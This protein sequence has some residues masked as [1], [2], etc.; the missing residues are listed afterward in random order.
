MGL[1]HAGPAH[2]PGLVFRYWSYYPYA[3][4]LVSLG[5]STGC[6]R[7]QS[8]PKIELPYV[9]TAPAS[10][11]RHTQHNM[12]NRRP[13]LTAAHCPPAA[14]WIPA[15]FS[16]R[17]ARVRPP[18]A[19]S[20]EEDLQPRG[21]VET[22]RCARS[23]NRWSLQPPQHRCQALV[24]AHG[25]ILLGIVGVVPAW[26]RV[27]LVDV[28]CFFLFMWTVQE[29]NWISIYMEY[30][31]LCRAWYL[32]KWHRWRYERVVVAYFQVWYL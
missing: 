15:L 22:L 28:N 25:G 6:H 1:C 8:S 29:Y 17:I 10:T 32:R 16:R 20:H 9:A 31:G 7:S 21:P 18:E 11:R 5:G 24:S 14:V 26:V 30:N 19:R 2:W 13:A 3:K 12:G 23:S 4:I 27:G